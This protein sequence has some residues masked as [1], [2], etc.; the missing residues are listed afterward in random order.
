MK[1]LSRLVLT[2][3]CG[4]FPLA[5]ALILV[6]APAFAASGG[7][8][9]DVSLFYDNLK[10]EGAWFNTTEYGDVWQPYIAYKNDSWRPY[11]DG[12]WTY[13]DGGWMFVSYESFGWAVYHYGRWTHLKDVGW[14][15]VPGTEWAPAWVAWR[16]NDPN[17]S[18][19]PPDAANIAATSTDAPAAPSAPA[20]GAPPPPAPPSGGDGG[21]GPGDGY[22]GWAPLP[23]E[24]VYNPGYSY[25]PTVDVDFGID[26]FDYCFTS[27]GLFGAPFVGGV[28]FGP[29]RSYYCCEHSLNITH[30]Y[31]NRNGAYRGVY[32]GGPNYERLRGR[33]D[34]PIQQL[35]IN[36]QAGRGADQFARVNGREANVY[37]PRFSH[38][39]VAPNGRVSFNRQGNLARAEVAPA[40]QRGGGPNAPAQNAAR[41]A[42]RRQG[43][44][45]R[46]QNARGAAGGPGKSSVSVNPNG[47]QSAPGASNTPLVHQEER[48]AG[49][50]TKA[51]TSAPRDTARSAARSGSG[52]RSRGGGA[53]NGGTRRTQSAGGGG[54]RGHGGGHG[55]GGHGGGHGGGGHGGGGHGG[56]GH[57]R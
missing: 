7:G 27:V 40:G 34:R 20:A 14:A 26:P 12:Y 28:I 35:R 21:P 36:R 23:P 39:G 57:K 3:A 46:Q 16:S 8:Q 1:R 30:L 37:A 33:T 45:L 17:G 48:T 13:T 50:R 10:D 4:L 5:S 32:A 52:R 41:E 6:P 43:E 9:V 44:G 2:A 55:G 15:W 56:G 24:A 54:G 49:E 29:D 47:V 19:T 42:F 11:T 18:A 53:R 25:G 38:H 22:I 31:Y 51:E